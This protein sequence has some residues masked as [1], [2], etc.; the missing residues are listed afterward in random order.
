MK[1]ITLVC[2]LAVSAL[3]Q[4]GLEWRRLAQGQS[5]PTPRFDGTIAY[6]P[7]DRRLYLFGGTDNSGDTNDLWYYDTAGDSWTRLNPT[8]AAPRAR[9]GHTL[10]FDPVRRQLLVVAGQAGSLFGDVW[11]YDI[12][13]NAWRQ[14]AANGSGPSNRYGHS[15]ILDTRRE[16]LVLSHGFT[17]ESGRFDDTWAFDLR[18]N[19]WQNITP[20]G[21]KPL[22]RCLHHAVY[23]AARDEMYLYGGCSSGAGPCPQGDLWILNLATNQW[24][25]AGLNPRPPGRQ[26]YG[27]SFD[28]ARARLV[29]FGGSASFFLAD[30]WEFDPA[31]NRWSPLEA[32]GTAPSARSRLQGAY[33]AG[34]GNFFF[35]GNAPQATNELWRLA[36]PAEPMIPAANPSLAA[37]GIR[38]VFDGGT[39]PFAP[40]EIVSLYGTDLGPADPVVASFSA[41][42]RLPVELGQ[43]RVFVGDHAAPL[44]F[45]SRGQ[46]NIQI[47]WEASGRPRLR[48]ENAGRRGEDREIEL[49][50]A[51]PK[52][53]NG[54][55]RVEDV[56]ILFVTGAGRTNPVAQTGAI[57]QAPL[58]QLIAPTRV[59]LNGEEG[60]VLFAGLAPGTAGLV[61]VNVRI[62]AS[63]RQAAQFRVRFESGA[64]SAE[65]TLVPAR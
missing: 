15:V 42:G 60:E 11:S 4:P 32:S 43:T 45:S 52:L 23:S 44:Y 56:L 54:L 58:G 3:A 16:R 12:A 49:R 19:R 65:T 10:N 62:P 25:E 53:Y 63:Q 27:I 22:R 38:G 34:Q 36:P 35:G 57:A 8:G 50:D 26:W 1:T 48:V 9:H 61:Q 31:A 29:L 41:A 46:V 20:S 39:G 24:R 5:A 59:L 33:A 18:T 47:P 2:L 37:N 51:A 30:T 14:L 21:S 13:T 55:I 17:S 64:A 28:D 7:Q 40:G 6:D